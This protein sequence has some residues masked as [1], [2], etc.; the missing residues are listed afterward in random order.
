MIRAYLT[1][2]VEPDCPPFLDG[3]R[4]V[5]EGLP[6]LLELLDRE[7]VPA[8]FFT[9]GEAAARHPERVR[10]VVARGHELGGHGHTHRAFAEMTPEEA[11]DE[12]A[13]STGVLRAFASVLSFRAPFLSFPE[14]Y[15]PLL[16]G[17]GYRLDSSRARYK[18]RPFNPPA[19]TSLLRV[20]ASVTSSALRLPSWIRDSYLRAQRSPVVLFVHPWEF[21]DLTRERIRWDCRFRT[22]EPALACLR[23][24]LRSLRE[25][26]ARFERMDALLDEPAGAPA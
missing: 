22:G 25:R 3:W 13:R 11:E 5:E 8:T 2:D 6:R 23:A 9:T 14:A 26:G 4:G 18:P 16:E 10:E 17:H 20:P 12:L 19:R 21:V 1:V 24:A 15:V 7:G